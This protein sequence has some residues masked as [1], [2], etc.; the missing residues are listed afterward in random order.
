MTGMIPDLPADP[1]EASYV[2]RM[3][4]MILAKNFHF[5]PAKNVPRMT[6]MILNVFY[7]LNSRLKYTYRTKQFK[8][9]PFKK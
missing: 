8:E 5:E 1:P 2:P 9:M 6:G 7:I 3:T 4:G